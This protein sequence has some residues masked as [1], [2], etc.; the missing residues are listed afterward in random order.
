MAAICEPRAGNR[1]RRAHPARGRAPHDGKRN[2]AAGLRRC[3]ARPPRGG[4]AGQLGSRDHALTPLARRASL[5][6]NSG[7][8][9]N[10]ATR[11]TMNRERLVHLERLVARLFAAHPA[12]GTLYGGRAR[13][14]HGFLAGLALAPARIGPQ[15]SLSAVLR[16]VRHFL[17]FRVIAS[18]SPRTPWQPLPSHYRS[19]EGSDGEGW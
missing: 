12:D 18:G 8:S 4:F 6:R 7:D 3:Q 14:V 2:D 9:E 10:A 16:G 19:A 17:W 5:P 1:D 13:S 15:R 11:Q